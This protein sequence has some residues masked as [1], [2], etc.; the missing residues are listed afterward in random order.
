M[1]CGSAF[2][3]CE[4]SC[5]MPSATLP[6]QYPSVQI[7]LLESAHNAAKQFVGLAK[8]NA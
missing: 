6:Y 4:R 7:F 8:I 5:V 1:A 2:F 3:F